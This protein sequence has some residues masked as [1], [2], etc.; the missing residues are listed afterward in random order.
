ME[1]IIKELKQARPK[2]PRKCKSYI[3]YLKDNHNTYYNRVLGVIE[4]LGMN[5]QS[6]GHSRKLDALKNN[7]YYLLDLKTR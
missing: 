5:T 7:A 6:I 2:K 3:D 4:V 1:E